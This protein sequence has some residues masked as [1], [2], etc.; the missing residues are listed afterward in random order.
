MSD[1]KYLTTLCHHCGGDGQK[2]DRNPSDPGARYFDCKEC[3]GTGNMVARCEFCDDDAVVVACGANACRKCAEGLEDE[4]PAEPAVVVDTATRLLLGDLAELGALLT[5]LR[6]AD[7]LLPRGLTWTGIYR[8]SS[9]IDKAIVRIK[10][11][12]GR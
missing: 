1:T 5:T 8:A 12:G 7:A 10:S 3:E 6:V 9:A 11:V 2:A 4:E